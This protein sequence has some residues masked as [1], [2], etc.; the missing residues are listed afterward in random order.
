MTTTGAQTY[1]DN[2][3][4]DADL[5]LST[6]N[7]AVLFAGTVDSEATEANDLT[8]STGTGNIT[9]TGA[10]GGAPPRSSARYRQQHRRHRFHEHR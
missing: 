3:R 1:N 9:F 6:T 10:V 7:N 4:I 5:T 8:V 2:V